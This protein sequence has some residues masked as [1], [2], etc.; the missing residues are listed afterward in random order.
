[1]TARKTTRRK[2]TPPPPEPE[3]P[4]TPLLARRLRRWALTGAGWALVSAILLVLFFGL[5]NPP[6]TPY[7]ISES[8]RLGSV[9]H[10]WAD[11]DEI[12]PVMARSVVA[13]EDAN[14][15]LHWG[16]DMAAIRA[17]INA[18]GNRGAST[19]SQ[20]VTKNVFLWQGRSWPR[21]ALE[22]MLTPLVETIWSKRRILEVYLNV[23]EFDEGVFGI[24]AAS[25]H[26]FGVEPARLTAQQAARL[27]AVLPDPKVRS[28]SNPGPVVRRRSAAILD[29]A[30][31]IR[32]DG[33]AACFE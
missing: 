30:N 25:E 15:C 11:W 7:M 8:V 22:A 32:R 14:F 21:K 29:G 5:V 28:A 12:A 19:L 1:M 24:R 27:A 6:A 2:A 31:T 16:F 3:A 33:R 10:E 4:P 13:A 23:A 20:Q 17:A 18:G 9:D 26:Y